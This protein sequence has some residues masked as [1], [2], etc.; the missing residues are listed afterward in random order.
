MEE[1]AFGD[2]FLSASRVAIWGL[3]L[4]GGS[5]AMALN[6]KCAGLA[7]I[8]SDPRTAARALELGIVARAATRPGDVLPGA[9]LVVLAVPVR[10]ILACLAELPEVCPGP[11]VVLDLGSTKRDVVAAMSGLPGRF[12]PVGGHPMCGKEKSSLEH[13][14]A[15]LYAQAPFALTA[16]K[17][18]SSRGRR[19]AEAVARAVGARPLW[20]AAD[21]HDQMVAAT[22]HAPFLVASALA[23]ATPLEA[24]PLV[25]PGFRSTARLAGSSTGMMLDILQTNA[26]NILAAIGQFKDALA[27]Y[28]ALLEQGDF[29]L[30]AEALD[31]GAEQYR[32]LSDGR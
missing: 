25:G 15:G 17:R 9:D 2:G 29:R 3:G 10:A 11:A 4:M 28:E 14:E 30:L 24:G 1:P 32:Q 18:T 27:R 16:L 20:I 6:G 31:Q 21:A 5:L 19:L 13:A 26:E 7:G 12:D 22:S 8:D 23:Q